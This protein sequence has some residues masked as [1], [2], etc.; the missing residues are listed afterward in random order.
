MDL[1]GEI[2]K[3]Q[4]SKNETQLKCHDLQSE[5]DRLSRLYDFEISNRNKYEEKIVN[6]RALAEEKQIETAA[7]KFEFRKIQDMKDNLVAENQVLKSM[8]A[9]ASNINGS[10][11]HQVTTFLNYNSSSSTGNTSPSNKNG[12]TRL[13]QMENSS[14]A[15]TSNNSASKL[16][17]IN[18]SSG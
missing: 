16:A 7:I 17:S 8:M 10:G 11:S 9:S 12:A 3:S 5:I 2:G 4:L 18:K 13:R 6:L 1:T 15:I 14:S